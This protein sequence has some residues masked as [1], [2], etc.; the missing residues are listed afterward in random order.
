MQEGSDA[1]QGLAWNS[2]MQEQVAQARMLLNTGRPLTTQL[3]FRA[4]LE[5]RLV[6]QGGLRILQRLEHLNY[7][8][9][10][11]RP[12]LRPIDWAHMAL[13]IFAK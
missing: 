2:L 9:F 13:S 4:G 12:V 1:S 8:V 6:I 10:Q 3:P 7:D 11:R 5:L